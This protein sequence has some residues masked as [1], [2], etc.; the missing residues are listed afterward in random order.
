MKE[1][2]MP[3]HIKMPIEKGLIINNFDLKLKN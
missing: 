3:V 1:Y 2:N